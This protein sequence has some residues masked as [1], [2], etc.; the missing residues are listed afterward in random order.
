MANDWVEAMRADDFARAWAINDCDLAASS[1]PPKHIGP[2]HLQRIWRGESLAGKRVLV[3]CYHGLGDTIQ[4]LRFMPPL[5]GLACGVTVWCQTEL[6]PLVER[7]AG[8]DRAL[9]LHEG[10]PETDFD[11]DIEIMEVPHALKSGRGQIEMRAPYLTLPQ[12]TLSAAIDRGAF[13]VGLVWEVGQWDKRRAVPPALLRSLAVPGIA[14][15]SLQRDA[16][17]EDLMRVGARDIST[18][19]IAKLG[20]LL[21]QLDLVIC[22]DTMVAHLAGALG[23]EAWVLLHADC[24]WRWPSAGSRSS[25]YPSLRLFH[26]RTAGDWSAVISQVREALEERTKSG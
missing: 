10:T 19:D 8:V 7:T 18:S 5:R 4:F 9:A 1:H 11:V 23:C 15:Y 6:L 17:K 13:A 12:K 24:D 26:Q 21:R 3:R 16:R 25:W 14:L 22:V 20:H 2:R